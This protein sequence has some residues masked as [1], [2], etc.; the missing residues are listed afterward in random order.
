MGCYITYML[1]VHMYMYMH[2]LTAPC[3]TY[4]PIMDVR[5]P[6]VTLHW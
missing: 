4:M 1:P 2:V 3:N 5:M 6:H